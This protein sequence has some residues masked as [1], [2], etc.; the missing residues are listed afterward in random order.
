MDNQEQQSTNHDD[1]VTAEPKILSEKVIAPQGNVPTPTPVTRAQTVPV[2][3]SL[4]SR[5]A[6]LHTYKQDMQELVRE[7]KISLV[8]AVAAESDRDPTTQ[9]WPESPEHNTEQKSTFMLIASI[10]L[11]VLGIA[12]LSIGY[13][14]YNLKKQSA[15]QDKQQAVTDDTPIFIEHRVRVDITDRN[16]RDVLAELTQL[17]SASQATLGSITEVLL[18]QKVWDTSVLQNVTYTL[19]IN[20]LLKS[21]GLSFS[22][23]MVQHMG[24]SYLLGMHMADKNSPFI[25]LTTDS[26]D[27]AFAGL[28]AWEKPAGYEL[29]PFFYDTSVANISTAE[30]AVI[31]NID[32]RVLRDNFGNIKVLY[33]F[34]DDNTF[35]I[36]NNIYTLTEVAR[37]Y[38]VRKSAGTAGGL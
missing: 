11:I 21:L 10:I 19:R 18:Q 9:E 7:R 1:S 38:Q 32:A 2:K 20:E 22:D 27:H 8:S 16:S 25:L 13:F 37:R 14:G 15:E 34:L 29:A 12:T 31:Q 30:N 23:E 26:Y 35:I 28:M 36:T 3:E 6:V 33:A 17:K 4:V 24:S 5:A